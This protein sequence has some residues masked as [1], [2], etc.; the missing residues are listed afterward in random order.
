[1]NAEDRQARILDI[2][3]QLSAVPPADINAT[4]RLRE[5]LGMDSVSSLELISMLSEEFDIDVDVEE[6]I[7]IADVK[8]VFALADKYLEG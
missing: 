6:A 3:S 1:M 7:E 2:V 8:G 4:D 5:D